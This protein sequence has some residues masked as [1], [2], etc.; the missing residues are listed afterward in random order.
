V[1]NN[2]TAPI[3]LVTLGAFLAVNGSGQNAGTIVTVAGTGTAGYDGDNKPAVNAALNVPPFVALDQA[4]N[5]YIAD[6]FNHRVRKVDTS[7]QITTFAGTGA[8]GYNG[9]NQPAT[10]AQL[11]TPIGVFADLAGNLFINDVANQRIRKVDTNGMITTVAGTGVT[12][13]NGDGIPATNAS[14]YNPV[15]AVV[16]T[17]GNIYIAD[18]SNHRI[19]KVDTSGIVTTIA[20]TGAGTPGFGGYNGDGPATTT[21]LNNPTAVALDATGNLYFSDQFNHRIRE[22]TGG[23]VVTIAGTGTAGFNGDGAPLNTNFNYPGGLILDPTG[24]IY[25]ADD[26]NQ[27][28]RKISADRSQVTTI[29]GTGT[30][31]YNG[32]SIPS[33][34]AQLNGTFGI[35]LDANGNLYLAD[36]GN[37]RIR[38]IISG[39]AGVGPPAPAIT[40]IIE[41]GNTPGRLSPGAFGVIGG[42]NFGN[43]PGVTVNGTAAAVLYAT[44]TTINFQIPPSIPVG[45]V[46][47]V[48]TTSAGASVP[49]PF[50]LN[51]VS[52][53]ILLGNFQNDSGVL[54]GTATPGDI[55]Q[56]A[57]DGLGTT[58]PPPAPEL[59]I[60]GQDVPVLS[61]S[62]ATALFAPLAK[63]VTVG[64]I[65][66]TVPNLT[67]GRHTLA[68]QAGGFTTANVVLVIFS[69]GLILTQ[70]GLTFNALQGGPKPAPQ[71]FSVLSGAGTI[72]YNVSTSTLSGGTGWLSVT[73]QSGLSQQ[74]QTGS[75]VSVTVD[76]TGLA[77]G[78]YYG[79]VQIS[80]QGVSNSPQ[81]V[82]VVL[83]VAAPNSNLGPSLDTSGLIF[84]GT[85]G[86]SPPAPQTVNITNPTPAALSFTSSLAVNSGANQFT[87]SPA[88]GSIN[89]G[90][91]LALK[92]QASLT[93]A[94]VGLDRATVTLT[95][96][97]GATRSISLLLVVASATNSGATITGATTPVRP[98]LAGCTPTKLLPVFTL[99]GA[100]FNVPAAWPT[101]LAVSVVDD[102]GSALISGKVGVSFNNGDPPLSLTSSLNG[103]WTATWPPRNP[104]ASGI[105]MTVNAAQ[106]ALNLSGS[107]TLTGGVSVNNVPMVFQGGI[108]DLASYSSEIA[109]GGMI[110]IF[111]SQLSAGNG[112]APVFP[113]PTLLQGTTVVLGGEALPL[114]ATSAGQVA[115]MVPYDVPLN[116]NLQLILQN[117]TSISTPQSIAVVPAVPGVFTPD[118]SGKGQG[119]IYTVDANGNQIL[120]NASAPAK[121]GDLLVIYCTG[122]GAVNPPAKAGF[123]TPTNSYTLTANPVT[124]TIGGETAA[125]PVFAGLIPGD[126]G[127]YEIVVAVPAG[128]PDNDTTQLT[129]TVLGQDSTP[130]TFSVRNPK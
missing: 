128:L 108:V 33:T 48:V 63:P 57:V 51:A 1:P 115:A 31:G 122:L 107:A 74:G 96:S 52:P 127:I 62:T 41:N 40:T 68:I 27:R 46:S 119:H 11:N 126:T 55:F 81:S 3:V 29:A 121:P 85:P 26:N 102:C 54:V 67:P 109:P 93:G 66:F 88:S 110:A 45:P 114:R 123:A 101:P 12:G 65:F 25:V 60:D 23:K 95:F 32:D 80:S 44:N 61:T 2:K 47:I 82:S 43:Q 104:Q 7:G 87:F 75:P 99:P 111:G 28:V 89:P 22:I 59:L 91:S 19:R 125:A 53:S 10:S 4:G 116:T 8:A 21:Q 86:G 97:S 118:L 5:I 39:A 42:T 112:D 13:Y 90:Q 24:A 35:G 56:F 16:D 15:R 92:V 73:P 113:L 36:S 18:Q 70:T 77:Q 49:F 124:V 20:G 38:K 83:N 84:V 117:G 120:A 58:L 79:L 76:P 129:L 100:S 64:T 14:F 9:D 6:Q 17:A 50:T 69:N 98:A 34:T 30:A 94:T 105:T 78:A 106:P 71:S 103:S 72:T 37:G 130:V